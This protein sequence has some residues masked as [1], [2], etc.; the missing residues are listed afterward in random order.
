VRPW[1]QREISTS[2]GSVPNSD[3]RAAVIDRLLVEGE[4]IVD[5]RGNEMRSYPKSIDIAARLGVSPSYVSKYAKLHRCFQRRRELRDAVDAKVRDRIA[6]RQA[7]RIVFDADRMLSMCDRILEKYEDAIK[8][9]GITKVT[10]ADVNTI[11]R[12]RRFIEGD[13]DSRREVVNR[14][15]TLETIQEAHRRMLADVQRMT[16]EECG[17]DAPKATASGKSPRAAS[18][19]FDDLG[20]E[21]D[22]NVEH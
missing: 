7:R 14:N 17:F 21:I 13:P 3:D 9:D 4:L 12:L 5:E 2:S 19:D 18:T 11:I 22:R 20:G 16:P 15:V 8:V 1:A 10:S 6:N